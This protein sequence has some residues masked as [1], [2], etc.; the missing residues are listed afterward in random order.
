MFICLDIIHMN[1]IENLIEH[2]ASDISL[3]RKNFT[4][5]KAQE[6]IFNTLAAI[7]ATIENEYPINTAKRRVMA[8][9][10][11]VFLMQTPVPIRKFENIYKSVK[12]YLVAVEKQKTLD[13]PKLL[14][15]I[16]DI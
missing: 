1:A 14:Q 12:K 4:K 15:R 10:E 3:M 13:D 5:V 2:L 16:A 7:E 8:K 9:I 6:Q 11:Q